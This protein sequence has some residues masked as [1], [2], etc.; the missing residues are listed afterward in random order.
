[1]LI[2]AN[3]NNNLF[4]ACL[5]ERWAAIADRANS[6]HNCTQSAPGVHFNA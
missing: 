6:A 2:A 4:C 5:L 1:M 3:D